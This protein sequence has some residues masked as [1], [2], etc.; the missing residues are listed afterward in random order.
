[1]ITLYEKYQQSTQICTDSRNLAPGCLF[2]CLKGANFDGNKF[3]ADVL[4]QGAKYVI[5]ENRELAGNPQAIV[6]DDA[7]KTQQQLAHYHREQL[8]I[9]VIGI[10]GTNGKTT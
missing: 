6:V 2:V 1:M 3:A 10:T 8:K 4:A 7:L 5:T 9:P